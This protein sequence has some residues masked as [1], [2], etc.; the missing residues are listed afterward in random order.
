[1]MRLISIEWFKLKKHRFFWIGMGLFMVLLSA[2]LISF[3]YFQLFGTGQANDAGNPMA[4]L[5]PKNMADAGFYQLPFIWQNTT[6]LAGFFKFIPAFLMLFFVTNEFEYRTMRQNIIDGLSVEQFFWSKL[7]TV[8]FFSILCTLVVF[9]S[10]LGLAFYHNEDLSQLWT[11]S[12]YILAYFAEILTLLSFTFFA[13]IVVRRSVIAIIAVLL[14]YY[15]VEPILVYQLPDAWEF[16]LPTRASRTLIQEPFSRLFQV[17]SFLN[18]EI[19]D[20]IPLKEHLVSYLYTLIFLASSYL[21][22]KKRDL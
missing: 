14:Y 15:V 2:L 5:I 3:G 19:L 13:G 8:F 9:L 21:I 16:I 12:Q 6:Y 17:N 4:A 11:Q 10:V 20:R 18:I 1:M 7:S 22:I